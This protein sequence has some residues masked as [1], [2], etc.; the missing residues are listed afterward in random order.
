M[1]VVC[2]FLFVTARVSVCVGIGRMLTELTGTHV[3]QH[4]ICF[5]FIVTW[6]A[7][8]GEVCEGED[9]VKKQMTVYAE[10]DPN[11]SSLSLLFSFT[12]SLSW[13][14]E[15]VKRE[16]QEK[17]HKKV[18]TVTFN[19]VSTATNFPSYLFGIPP[20]VSLDSETPGA[21]NVLMTW[22]Q[23]GMSS[24]FIACSN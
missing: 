19:F 16:S 6:R 9:S 22:P 5:H 11:N 1:C 13:S 2:L 15:T 10:G 8:G 7:D 4:S 18:R 23:F 3:L 24:S 20:L 21:V 14:T 12:S 17:G